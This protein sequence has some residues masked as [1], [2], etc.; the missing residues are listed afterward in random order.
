MSKSLLIRF[1]LDG[2]L[3]AS[4]FS[5]L[6]QAAD[7]QTPEPTAYAVFSGQ[8]GQFRVLG[9][10]GVETDQ[11]WGITGDIPISG[12]DF[13]GDGIADYVVWRPSNGYWY[14]IPS[15][16]GPG[17][18]YAL[19]WGLPG[20]IPAAGDYDGDGKTDFAIFR[21]S[22]GTY[23]IL[24]N[25]NPPGVNWDLAYTVNWGLDGDTPVIGD[26]D[27]DGKTDVAMYRPSTGYWYIIPSSKGP[28]GAYSLQWGLPG[29]IPASGDYD[30]DSKTDFAIFRPSTGTFWILPNKN[31]PGINWDL[32]YTV[33]WGIPG[34]IPVIRDYDGDGKSDVA[35]YRPSAAT[36]FVVSSASGLEYAKQFGIVNS[37]LPVAVPPGSVVRAKTQTV[38]TISGQV[39]GGGHPLP[40][41]TLTLSGTASGTTMTVGSDGYSFTVPAGG[42]YTVTPSLSGYVFSPASLTFPNIAA[43]QTAASFNASTVFPPTASFTVLVNGAFNEY[44]PWEDPTDPEYQAIAATFGGAI[45]T[46][47]WPS[48][49]V[50]PPFYLDI[51][52]GVQG[53]IDAINAHSFA[54]GETLN[55]VAHSHG[56]NVVKM[57]TYNINHAITNVVNLG[58]P[59]NWDL[60]GIAWPKVGNYCQVSSFTDPIQFSGSSP[61]QVGNYLYDEYEVAVYTALEAQDLWDGDWEAAAYDALEIA[62]YQADALYWWL[63]TKLAIDSPTASNVLYASYSHSALHT[64]SVWNQVVSDCSLP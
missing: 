3:T 29:D 21:P 46:Y 35:V 14:I 7:A 28:D 64:P 10:N 20:D 43:N 55:I 22:T 23:W 41:V 45:Y 62:F 15:S 31:P 58:T 5:V 56:G 2:L 26:F 63:T 39:F 54:P 49:N 38:Y 30:G 61:G 16:M 59:Q 24:P 57:A 25:K 32:A 34:D 13:D 1:V 8:L 9:S 18:E 11:I 50:Y 44:P 27:G 53:L 48:D 47:H 19:Q 51:Y 33:I 60:P 52:N 17:S 12:A 40:G 42:T 37:D 36:W 4:L 6:A